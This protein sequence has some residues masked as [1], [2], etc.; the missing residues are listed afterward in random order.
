MAFAAASGSPAVAVEQ[1]S[2][3]SAAG[4]AFFPGHCLDL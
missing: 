2:A 3:Y 1:N 4:R